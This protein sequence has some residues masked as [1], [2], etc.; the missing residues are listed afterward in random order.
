MNFN[1]VKLHINCDDP[2]INRDGGTSEESY[3]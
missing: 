2:D 1:L 3:E